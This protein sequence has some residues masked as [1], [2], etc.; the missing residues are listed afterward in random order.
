V[1]GGGSLR[2]ERG[3]ENDSCLKKR[4]KEAESRRNLHR[5]KKGGKIVV[6][7]QTCTRSILEFGHRGREGLR[8]QEKEAGQERLL[9]RPTI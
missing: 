4:P 1:S 9:P 5:P 6:I 7:P 3:I 8:D 2:L